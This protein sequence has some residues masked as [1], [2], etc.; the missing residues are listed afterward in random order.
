MAVF[1]EPDDIMCPVCAN[2]REDGEVSK[3]NQ[4]RGFSYTRVGKYQQY[5]CNDCT[6]WHRGRFTE[7]PKDKRKI[8]TVS[9]T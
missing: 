3:G 6:H 4:K 9:S 8:L 7:Y 1:E 2:I 5:Y